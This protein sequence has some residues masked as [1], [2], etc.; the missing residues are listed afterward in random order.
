[1]LLTLTLPQEVIY[2]STVL[3]HGKWGAPVPGQAAAAV[4]TKIG[5]ESVTFCLCS[6]S[7]GVKYPSACPCL[8]AGNY[9]PL[10]GHFCFLREESRV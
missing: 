8:F 7:D 10:L 1:M 6:D 3:P 2:D 4:L 5:G 9:K